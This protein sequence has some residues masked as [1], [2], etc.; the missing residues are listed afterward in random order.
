MRGVHIVDSICAIHTL[1]GGEEGK[2]CIYNEV[3]C[4]DKVFP[5]VSKEGHSFAQKELILLLSMPHP[6]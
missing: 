4:Y 1:I 6:F 5:L 2:K 3:K